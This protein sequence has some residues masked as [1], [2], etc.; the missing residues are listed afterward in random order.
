MEQ[1]ACSPTQFDPHALHQV[2]QRTDTHR[3]GDEEAAQ[4]V[5]YR[6]E[7]AHHDGAQLHAGRHVDGHDAEEGLGA[8]VEVQEEHEPEEL[9]A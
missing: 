6:E 1:Y 2:S 3:P 5:P 4:Q 7:G 9:R 8:E